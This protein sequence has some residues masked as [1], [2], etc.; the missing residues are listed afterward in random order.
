M[1]I[2]ISEENLQVLPIDNSI[3]NRSNT[4]ETLIDNKVIAGNITPQYSVHQNFFL[5]N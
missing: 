4:S 2:I 3:L 5:Q 1:D